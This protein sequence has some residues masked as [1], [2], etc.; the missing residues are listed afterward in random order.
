MSDLRDELRRLVER[1]P[2]ERLRDAINLLN[3]QCMPAPPRPR[4]FRSSWG[5]SRG[6]ET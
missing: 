5:C 3:E 2:E 4:G 6:R 1:I